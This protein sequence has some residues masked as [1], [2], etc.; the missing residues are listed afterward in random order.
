MS[1]IDHIQE[2]IN[3]AECLYSEAQVEG[4]LD[5][6]AAEITEQYAQSN[7]IFLCVVVGGIVPMGKLLTRMHFPLEVDYIHATRYQGDIVAG[8]KLTWKATPTID[9]SERTVII[10]DDILDKGVTLSE[11]VKFCHAKKAAKVLTAAL[12]DK[13]VK[14]SDSGIVQADFT[15]LAVED[16]YLFGYGLD[17]K[18]YLRNMPGIYAISAAHEA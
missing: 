7:P 1:P 2:V 16:R 4:A 5:K 10:V 15:G 11:I 6:M 9:L 14:R 17:Y 18:G 13:Q 3:Q 12:V 8:E